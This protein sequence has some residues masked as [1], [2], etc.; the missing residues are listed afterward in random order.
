M[1]KIHSPGTCALQHFAIGMFKLRTSSRIRCTMY[2][3]RCMRFSGCIKSRQ[4]S[5]LAHNSDATE[6]DQNSAIQRTIIIQTSCK[7]LCTRKSDAGFLKV[8]CLCM[9]F[10]T[11]RLSLNVSLLILQ[12]CTI[13]AR[14]I[15]FCLPY[16]S[17]TI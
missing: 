6:C 3:I 8:V 13:I 7:V 4:N 5:R 11:M 2:R 15:S 9:C 1:L 16:F 10:A 14:F 17:T 12:H